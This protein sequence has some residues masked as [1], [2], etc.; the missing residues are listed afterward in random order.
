MLAETTYDK[1]FSK[2]TANRPAPFKPQ[3]MEVS[4]PVPFNSKTVYDETYTTWTSE[5]LEECKVKLKLPEDN[6][7]TRNP[8]KK[9]QATT[10]V[11]V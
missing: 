9:F 7:K 10:T 11:K 4:A 8:G 2:K 3:E 5:Q 6:L 1:D